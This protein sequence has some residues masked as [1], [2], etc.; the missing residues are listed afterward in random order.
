MLKIFLDAQGL[1]Q[2]RTVNKEI[3][4]PMD[5]VTR[6]YPEKW[7]RNS[8]FLL[9]ENALAHRSLVV[10]KDLAKQNVMT[11]EHSSYSLDLSLPD[12]SY[13]RN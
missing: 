4:R 13:F 5:A 3:S 12:F 2:E 6:K 7:A 10:K 9:Q 8:W 1:V 11:L